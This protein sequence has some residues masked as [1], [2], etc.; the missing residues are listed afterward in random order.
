[1]TEKQTI[2]AGI[3]AMLSK[4]VKENKEKRGL[5]IHKKEGGLVWG[6]AFRRL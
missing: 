3:L 6:E 1:V 2:S 5:G 4:E